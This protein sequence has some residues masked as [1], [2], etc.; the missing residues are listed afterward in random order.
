MSDILNDDEVAALAVTADTAPAADTPPQADG[1]T[2]PA[3]DDRPRDE[4]GRFVPKTPDAAPDGEQQPEDG[5]QPGTVPQQALHAERERRKAAEA[6]LAEAAPIL[7]KIAEM[8]ARAANPQPEQAPQI[9]PADDPN[10]VEH[11]KAR[12]AQLEG[13]TQ[14]QERAQQLQQVD[15]Y[16]M[17]VLSQQATADEETFRAVQPDYD[18][19]INYLVGARARELSAYG[20][21]PITIQQTVREEAADIVR[22]ALSQGK[23][24]AELSYQIAQFR[25]YRPAQGGQPAAQQQQQQAPTNSAQ[26]TLDAIA[27]ARAMNKTPGQGGGGAPT[28]LN[29]TTIAAMSDDEFNALYAT[30]E[31]R[32]L[33]DAL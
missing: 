13:R 32:K 23:S 9:D 16:E 15:D 7:A 4:Q 26:A 24:P 18:D 17:R 14:Q 31:G 22:T 19:A 11:L 20:M 25:G 29:A 5:K 12:I 3:S 27:K 30:P 33:I 8:R 21:D 1:N 28:E 10:G 2:P 6:K